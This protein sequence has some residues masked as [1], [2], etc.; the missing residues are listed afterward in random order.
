MLLNA[1]AVENLANNT[2]VRFRGMV[3]DMYNPEYY[4][5]KYHVI[6]DV[7]KETETRYGKY[8]DV[9]ALRVCCCLFLPII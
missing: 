8:Q 7:S 3:Q 1:N 9:A 6:H 2:L 5:E 4:Y